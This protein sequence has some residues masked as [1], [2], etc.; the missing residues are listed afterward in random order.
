MFA[1]VRES[2]L[3]EREHQKQVGTVN[4]IIDGV[5]N[6][7]FTNRYG[8][9]LSPKSVNSAIAR[10]IHHYNREEELLSKDIGRA[11]Q[12]LPHITNHEKRHTVILVCL[13]A[14]YTCPQGC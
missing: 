11:P 9:V 12:L 3:A 4:T 5:G 13:Y 1:E 7:V 6:W 8:T 10:I 14:G 2:L